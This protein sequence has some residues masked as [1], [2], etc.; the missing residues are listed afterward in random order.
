M[1]AITWRTSCRFSGRCSRIRPR[2]HVC[3]NPS[4]PPRRSIER[5]GAGRRE[6]R[7]GPL[8]SLPCPCNFAADEDGDLQKA[9]NVNGAPRAPSRLGPL[10]LSHLPADRFSRAASGSRDRHCSATAEAATE[11]CPGSMRRR[12]PH[13]RRARHRRK[14]IRGRQEAG[15]GPGRGDPWGPFQV[16]AIQKIFF[17][18]RPRVERA[19]EDPRGPPPVS[20]R[21]P[22]PL[23]SVTPPL[24]AS[25]REQPG[26]NSQLAARGAAVIPGISAIT[27]PG[28]ARFSRDRFV[29]YVG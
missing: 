28:F 9:A 21:P 26:E 3:C 18:H 25:S 4:R 24:R 13:P 27:V 5:V 17:P 10:R 19:R 7:R 14:W 1:R 2:G 16:A 20:C 23:P 11:S 12:R 22:P 29:R 6:R 8:G 15:G